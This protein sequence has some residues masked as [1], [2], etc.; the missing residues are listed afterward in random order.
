MKSIKLI[1]TLIV[2]FSSSMSLANSG[3]SE[4]ISAASKH[5]VLSVSHG[6]KASGQ[7][8][9][10]VVAVPLIIVGQVG[11]VSLE[12]GE[13]LMKNAIGSDEL[14]ITELTITADP[15]P[16]SVMQNTVDEK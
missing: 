3:A 15:A 9:S 12:A 13:S 1:F 7:V 10:G 16:Q 14:V 2:L 11:S 8:V 4:N 5:S 6:V